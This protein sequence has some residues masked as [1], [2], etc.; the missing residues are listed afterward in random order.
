MGRILIAERFLVDSVVS[1]AYTLNDEKF[2][3][4]F[5]AELMLRLIPK[6]SLLVHLD[7]DYEE[8]LERRGSMADPQD[9]ANF[10]RLLYN[11]LSRIL[12]AISIDTSQQSIEH[13]AEIIREHVLRML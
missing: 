4:S 13:T 7:T 12:G 1:I 6:N 3:P 11:R 10:Q 8:I 5:M 9:F 2:Y